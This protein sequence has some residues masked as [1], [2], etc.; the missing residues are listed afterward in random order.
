MKKYIL[1]GFLIISLLAGHFL[2]NKNN[3]ETDQIVVTQSENQNQ[4]LPATQ[5]VQSQ[6]TFTVPSSYNISNVP[7]TSQAPFAVWDDLHNEA[8]EEASLVIANFYLTKNNL[9][10]DL[11]DSDIQRMINWEINYFGVNKNLTASETMAMAYNFYGLN[12]LSIKEIN[13][14]SDIKKEISQNHLVIVPTAGRLLGNPNFKTPGPIYHMLVISGYTKD[15][16]ITQDV[17][18]KN[19]QN[20]VYSQDTLF[21]AIHDWTGDDSTISSGEKNIITLQSNLN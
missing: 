17:G 2:G 10:A 1:I 8:C 20:Y 5:N 18:T 12:N 9:T 14:V 6:S 16:F 7:F 21:N 4:N 11:A 13:S 3:I 15:Q 19:G